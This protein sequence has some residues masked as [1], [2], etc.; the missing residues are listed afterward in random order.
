[1]ATER[2]RCAFDTNVL[3][4]ALLLP[5]SAPRRALDTALDGGKVILS[6]PVFREVVNVLS[7]EKLR[8]YVSL[9]T[10]QRFLASLARECEWVEPAVEVRACRDPKDDKFLSLAVSGNA[11]HLV[12]G[13]KDLLALH[14]FRGVHIVS[15]RSFLD[16]ERAQ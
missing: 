9:T 4:S 16:E 12:T 3:V 2:L 10:A 5:S 1:M 11:S 6:L 14:P 13:D 7:R 15:P 8:R